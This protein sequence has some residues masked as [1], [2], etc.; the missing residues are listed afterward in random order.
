MYTL[1]TI[2][3]PNPKKFER[4]IIEKSVENLLMFGRSTKKLQH[5]KEQFVLTYQFLSQEQVSTILSQYELNTVLP[6]TVTDT[7]VDI[8]ETNVLMDI[9]NREYPPSGNEYRENLTIV[10]TEVF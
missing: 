5:R 2:I 3:L 9:S 1:G 4:R 8:A 6:F 10:L 7:E